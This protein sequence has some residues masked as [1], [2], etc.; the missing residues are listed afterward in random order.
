MRFAEVYMNDAS[1]AAL[2]LGLDKI[3]C[4]FFL[5]V[6]ITRVEMSETLVEEMACEEMKVVEE[7]EA[8]TKQSVRWAD[9]EDE[10]ETREE[11]PKED[12]QEWIKFQEE[13]TAVQE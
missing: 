10:H 5:T 11:R 6:R 13:M 4:K 7:C 2:A 12:Q 9:N 3:S 1:H 8:G